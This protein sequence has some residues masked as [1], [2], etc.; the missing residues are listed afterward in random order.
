MKERLFLVQGTDNLPTSGKLIG[1][2][3]SVYAIDEQ[4]A[5]MKALP[6]L[7]AHPGLTNVTVDACPYGFTIWARTLPGTR[8]RLEPCLCEREETSQG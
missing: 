1:R 4:E 6:W 2:I 3:A 7:L 5:R 8:E